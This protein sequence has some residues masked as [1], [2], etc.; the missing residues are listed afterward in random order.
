MEHRRN[1]GRTRTAVCEALES[2][3]G[4]ASARTLWAGMHR[5]E[6]GPSLTTLYRALDALVADGTVAVI[7]DLTGTRLYRA[8]GAIDDRS[9]HIVCPG[10]GTIAHYP[11]PDRF[12]PTAVSA[13]TGADLCSPEFEV[14]G[15]CVDC[16]A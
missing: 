4:Y 10:C 8:R 9:L 7:H 1:Y 15:V 16:A 11:L 12:R 2:Q 3:S 13:A 14:L 6:R 5:R